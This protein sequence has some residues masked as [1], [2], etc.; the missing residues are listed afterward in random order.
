MNTISQTL[1]K[2]EAIS[3]KLDQWALNADVIKEIEEFPMNVTLVNEKG[4]I[5]AVN[6][7]FCEITGYKEKE[8]IGKPFAELFPEDLRENF[9]KL[10]DKFFESPF[11]F[12][13]EYEIVNKDQ[14]PKD[15]LISLSPIKIN[16]EKKQ[17]TLSLEISDQI[18]RNKKKKLAELEGFDNTLQEKIKQSYTKLSPEEIAQSQEENDIK[19]QLHHIQS[20]VQLLKERQFSEKEQQNMLTMIADASEK[21]L[22][23]LDRKSNLELL[24]SGEYNLVK[25]E[26][27]VMKSIEEANK[28]LEKIFSSKKLKLLVES[29]NPKH[30]DGSAQPYLMHADKFYVDMM[31]THLLQNAA[32]ASP[33]N[34]TILV[35]ITTANMS[36]EISVHNWG[37]VPDDVREHFFEKYVTKGKKKGTGLGTYICKM[38]AKAHQGMIT[39]RSDKER[40][41]YVVVVFPILHQQQ[42]TKAA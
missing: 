28:R 2:M 22:Q 11:K 33:K 3:E 6:Q 31:L 27:D 20:V 37:T 9:I 30:L 8:L 14:E 12:S 29:D 39:M 42:S 16:G 18:N 34:E 26:M 5:E 24:E 35:H 38:I 13:G 32:E 15:L 7:T 19:N 17:I 1:A 40:G 25:D 41:T 10:H 36:V 23:E 4:I 21:A